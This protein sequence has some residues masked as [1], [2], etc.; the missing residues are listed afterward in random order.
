MHDNTVQMCASYR[1][2]P[3]N[4][5]GLTRSCQ[6]TSSQFSLADPWTTRGGD[7]PLDIAITSAT[8]RPPL[9]SFPKQ[10]ARP[11]QVSPAA[12]LTGSLNTTPPLGDYQP[13]VLNRHAVPL[14]S[15]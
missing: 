3:P 14:E 10:V 6:F 12:H 2:G 5:A 9:I 13:R 11:Y 7:G 1:C 8:S 4:P 15:R